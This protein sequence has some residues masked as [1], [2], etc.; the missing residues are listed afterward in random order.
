VH[1]VP[2]GSA[3]SRSTALGVVTLLML[4]A[5]SSSKATSTA[6]SSAPSPSS[7]AA[8]VSSTTASP[9]ASSSGSASSAPASSA[10]TT[11]SGS[12]AAATAKVD[13]NI[14]S[15]TEVTAALQAAGVS[16]PD[17]WAKE[18]VE[19]R[20]YPTNDPT[21]AKLKQNIAKYNPSPAVVEGIISV[22]KL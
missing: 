4:T 8:S 12:P 3:L 2:R 19:Y 20:P 7:T 21:F 18:V 14:A 10:A 11:T 1:F 6:T 17:R 22:L 16:S 9:A 5:C 15:Q 13:A